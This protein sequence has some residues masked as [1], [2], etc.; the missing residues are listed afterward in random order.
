MKSK[1]KLT[2]PVAAVATLLAVG[3]TAGCTSQQDTNLKLAADIVASE[4]STWDEI[5]IFD[6]F[7]ECHKFYVVDGVF[8]NWGQNTLDCLEKEARL[9]TVAERVSTKLSNLGETSQPELLD[10]TISALAA[11]KRSPICDRF[12]WNPGT[13]SGC[14]IQ[15]RSRADAYEEVK[16]VMPKWYPINVS[17]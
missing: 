16:R 7:N 3:T 2:F 4:Q 12:Q 1:F 11:V 17:N 14:G 13:A 9:S 15:L 8:K 6:A 10:E 5:E